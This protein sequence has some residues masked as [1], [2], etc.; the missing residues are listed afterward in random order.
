ME[1][2]WFRY[3]R[4]SK[5]GKIQGKVIIGVVGTHIGAGS[6]HFSMVLS[7]YL[8]EY[9]GKKTAFIECNPQNELKFLETAYN[10]KRKDDMLDNSFS[11]NRVTLYKNIKEQE[12]GEIMGCGY[13]CIV[14]DLGINIGQKKN[15]FLRCDKKVVVSSLTPW[16]IYEL[17]TFL[18]RMQQKGNRDW[19]YGIP[20]TSKK[21]IRYFSKEYHIPMFQI[22]FEPDPFALSNDTI[23][24]F[25]KLI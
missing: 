7:N 14:M 23:K 20:F 6:T 12:I 16:K 21:E 17:E 19:R 18:N 22:P 5:D 24:M 4:A 13:D 2:G 3:K 8:S 11:I 9:L 25:Q 1:R 15:E 10:I